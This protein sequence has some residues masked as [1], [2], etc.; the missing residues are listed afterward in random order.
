[1][2]E[3]VDPESLQAIQD[4]GEDVLCE[5]I[6]LFFQTTPGKIEL[7]RQALADGDSK[8][9]ER[10]AHFMKGSC[11]N[12]GALPMRALCHS[13]QELGVSGKL[14]GVAAELKKLERE[15]TN[16]QEALKRARPVKD[17]P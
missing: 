11:S 12:V 15:Y 16:V 6:D 7:L 10:A 17:T 3:A 8:G 13:L 5:V 1:M 4:L 9:V 2:S 14:E